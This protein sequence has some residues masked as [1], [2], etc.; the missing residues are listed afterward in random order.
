MLPLMHG[1]LNQSQS[2]GSELE[3]IAAAVLESLGIPREVVPL[4]AFVVI[5]LLVK[6][7]INFC[8]QV[9]AEYG[10]MQLG[11]QLRRN[12]LEGV[13]SA[14]W[15]FL[16]L[17]QSGQVANSISGEANRASQ[18]YA[19]A[20]RFT[21]NSLQCAVYVCVGFLISWQLALCALVL[22]GVMFYAFSWIIRL[23]R[24]AGDRQTHASNELLVHVTDAIGNLKVIKAMGRQAYFLK[25]FGSNIDDLG[26]SLRRIVL[27]RHA[28]EFANN[29]YTVIIFA[30]GLTVALAFFSLSF[31]ELI[32]MAIVISRSMATWRMLQD[33]LQAVAELESAW[34]AAS[35]LSARYDVVAEKSTGGVD[36]TLVIG[37][38]FRDVSFAYQDS[39]I[40]REASLTIPCKELT[41]IQGPSGAGKTTLI[42]LLLGL[43][44]PDRGYIRID[45]NNLQEIDI[46][47][48]RNMVGYVPQELT[49]LHSSVRNNI[50]LGRDN[51]TD[52]DIYQALDLAGAREVVNGL[53]EGL[54][55]N[56]GELGGR[57]SGGQRQRIALAR[58]I[59]GQPRLLVLDEVT[60]ALDPVTEKEICANI[61]GLREIF[62]IVA[63]T[64]RPVW[65]SVAGVLYQV[66][67]GRVVKVEP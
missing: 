61:L 2:S 22:G 28:R 9:F 29:S 6:Y 24:S 31:S 10:A 32:V 36:P 44:I 35:T 62:T 64:H 47:K 25:L 16:V 43:Y 11:I 23:S 18:A 17:R 57:L 5:V 19:A 55:E 15:S 7:A 67:G 65:T 20:G 41:V 48:W 46:E 53:P 30:L 52:D 37:C 50:T 56:V 51:L 3:A 38:E 27:L 63:I 1:L 26:K 49:L 66:E 54:D 34:R 59:V 14:N 8:A 40:V 13:L 58:A 39:P 21:A 4:A 12:L 60:S 33:Q 45:G 42:D